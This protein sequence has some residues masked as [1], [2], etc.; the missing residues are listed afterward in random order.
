MTSSDSIKTT[1]AATLALVVGSGAWWYRKHNA[2]TIYVKD[3]ATVST[4]GE[5]HDSDCEHDEP[6][7]SV[8]AGIR[9]R[10]SIFPN[11]WNK[12]PE[13][14]DDSVIRS[15]LDA[16]MWGPFHGKNY[17]GS[18]HP[19]KF[20][21]L[22]KQGMVDMQKMTLDYY[23]KNWQEVGWANGCTGTKEEYEAW[24]QMTE[25]EIT[26]RWAPCTHMIAIVMRRQS[27][28]KRLPEWEEMAAVGA[29]VQNMHV[30]STKFKKLACYWSSWHDAVRDSD[31][32]KEFLGMEPEDK[33][34]G[35]FCVAQKDPKR[36]SKDRRKRDRS[37]LQVEWRS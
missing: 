26:G 35:I 9:N 27:G 31:E 21:V 28:P 4:S 1:L 25:E 8:L 13:P 7:L 11:S 5:T 37:I 14:L 19:A 20:V 6:D 10:R 24:R 30:Q 32:M 15:L 18:Q 33:C 34:M 12:N 22:G 36:S 23:D 29:A 17:K 3:D 16:A 2:E